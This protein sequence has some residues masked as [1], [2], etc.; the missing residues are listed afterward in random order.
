MTSLNAAE[1]TVFQHVF[2]ASTHN[3]LMH[4]LRDLSTLKV[5]REIPNT[6]DVIASKLNLNRDILFRCLRFI[7][8]FGYTSHVDD[9]FF[10]HSKKSLELTD[11]NSSGYQYLHLR[12]TFQQLPK[13]FV[14]SLK[15]G[16]VPFEDENKMA[17]FTIYQ[18]AQNKQLRRNYN[19]F[20]EK[21]NQDNLRQII[22]KYDFFSTSTTNINSDNINDTSV[23][24]A[25]IGGNT[26]DLIINILKHYNSIYKRKKCDINSINIINGTSYSCRVKGIL[27]D[28]PNVIDQNR[29]LI[30][31]N[32]NKELENNDD[33]IEI[34]FL[35]GNFFNLNDVLKINANILILKHILHDFNDDNC[36]KILKNMHNA[37]CKNK[38]ICTNTNRNRNR[39]KNKNNTRGTEQKKLLIIERIIDGCDNIDENKDCLTFDMV[40]L[41]VHGGKERSLKEF[42]DLFVQSGFKRK[43]EPISVG[44]VFVIEVFV[45]DNC[46]SCCKNFCMTS[47]L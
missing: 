3:L 17:F 38:N 21:I 6:S 11:Y 25:D 47:K 2:S 10:Q 33:E 36:V 45:D 16:T 14:N 43:K 26:G 29:D 12:Y 7:S 8:S 15:Y 32:I 24:I 28:L 22:D 19:A 5:F 18:L 40:M 41:A 30:L 39:N 1:Q 37:I 9:K 44:Y 13:T 27:F 46:T 34:S 20:M 35:K 23:V 42:D 31:N 4:V